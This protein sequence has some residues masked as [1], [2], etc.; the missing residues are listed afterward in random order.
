MEKKKKNIQESL[1]L[2]NKFYLLRVEESFSESAMGTYFMNN[3]LN[4]NKSKIA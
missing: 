2:V 3:S 1:M 4:R